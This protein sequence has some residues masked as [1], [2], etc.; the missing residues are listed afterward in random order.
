[1]AKAEFT[2]SD[3]ISTVS[4]EHSS[5]IEKLHEQLIDLGCDLMIK[6]AKSGYSASYKWKKKTVMNWVFRKSGIFA[7]IYGDHAGQYEDI[8]ANLPTA[9]QSKM[10]TSRDCKRLLD[11][12]AC[13]DTCVQGFIY[14]LNGN[15]LRKCRNDGMFFSL[16]DETGEH[17][18]G[19]VCAEIAVRKS[20]S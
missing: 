15:T 19:L 8:L 2:F 9:M 12:T 20:A 14:N 16:T 7:R 17:I 13:S 11:P 5:F 1:M 4:P 10:S 3:F 18:A 6:E